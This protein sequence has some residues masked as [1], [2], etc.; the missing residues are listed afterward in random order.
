VLKDRVLIIGHNGEE[1]GVK[2]R[3]LLNEELLNFCS[4]TDIVRMITLLGM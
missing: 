2:A 1:G 4:S 3:K